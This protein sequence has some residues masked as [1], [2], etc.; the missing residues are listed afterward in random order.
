MKTKLLQLAD[1]LKAAALWLFKITLRAIKVIVEE[2]I[3]VLQKLDTL[4]TN[5]VA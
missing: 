1:F 3:L 4:L 2:T 5:H